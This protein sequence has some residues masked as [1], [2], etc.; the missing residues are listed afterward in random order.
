[1]QPNIIQRTIQV[2]TFH[3]TNGDSLV[4]AKV[5]A[6]SDR[7]LNDPFFADVAKK[8]AKRHGK[9]VEWIVLP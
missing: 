2:K 9:A 7:P 5:A 3:K 4:T 6:R 1:M 8:L